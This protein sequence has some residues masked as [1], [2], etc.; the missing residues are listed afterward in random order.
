MPPS[1]LRISPIAILL[2]VAPVLAVSPI[3]AQSGVPQDVRGTYVARDD[4]LRRAVSLEAAAESGSVDEGDRSRRSFEASRIRERLR[5]GDFQP[6]DRLVIRVDG[7]EAM[8]D[9]FVVRAGPE[10][11]IP[12]LPPLSLVGVLRSEA[13]ERVAAHV[14]AYVRDP[15]VRIDVLLNVAVIGNVGRPGFYAMPADILLGDALMLAGGPTPVADMERIEIRRDGFKFWN[16]ANLRIAL[17]DG[18][19]LDRLDVRSGD[20]IH[21]GERRRVSFTAVLQTLGVVAGLAAL[22][23]SR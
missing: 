6:G 10:I 12:S 8:S 13:Q 18:W 16:R 23:V 9:T 21:I 2:V 1:A 14:A 15:R 4:L 11:E 17:T 5:V 22:L 3:A 7:I 20:E 19:T